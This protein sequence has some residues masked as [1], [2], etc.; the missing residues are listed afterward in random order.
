MTETGY[1]AQIERLFEDPR[2]QAGGFYGA[3]FRTDTL[4]DLNAG[5][6]RGYGRY[7]YHSGP[8]EEGSNSHWNNTNG[9]GVPLLVPSKVSLLISGGTLPKSNQV[10]SKRCFANL[11][12]MIITIDEPDTGTGPYAR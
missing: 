11:H 9:N 5:L 2:G 12:L 10:P 6:S 4:H 7:A 1:Q 8:N 3:F